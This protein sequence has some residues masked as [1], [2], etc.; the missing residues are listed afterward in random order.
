VPL[1]SMNSA[2]LLRRVCKQAAAGKHTRACVCAR[3]CGCMRGGVSGRASERACVCACVCVCACW[4]VR[5]PAR[6]RKCD[7]ACRSAPVSECLCARVHACMRVCWRAGV[8]ALCL[9]WVRASCTC[10]TECRCERA[11]MCGQVRAVS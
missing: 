4:L 11:R 5:V 1:A 10:L 7:C 9:H 8:G 3:V 6:A 2:K